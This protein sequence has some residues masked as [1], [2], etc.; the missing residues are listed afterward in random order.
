MFV[1]AHHPMWLRTPPW[2]GPGWVLRAV[3]ARVALARP[4][5]AVAAAA[6]LPEPSP[7][8]SSRPDAAESRRRRLQ[9]P[10]PS[11]F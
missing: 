6:A 3:G 7:A 5:V 9:G 8:R 10:C 2:T 4:G 11:G 1:F